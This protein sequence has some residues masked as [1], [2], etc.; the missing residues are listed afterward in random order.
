[1]E[2]MEGQSYDHWVSISPAAEIPRDLHQTNW[3]LKCMVPA[4]NSNE[5]ILTVLKWPKCDEDWILNMHVNLQQI[6]RYAYSTQ[7]QRLNP[8]LDG[9]MRII[10]TV[11]KWESMILSIKWQCF[12]ARSVITVGCWWRIFKFL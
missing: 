2:R 4:C 8:K 10:L 1:M 11:E 3:P 9:V 5:I 12:T 7:Q 6:M